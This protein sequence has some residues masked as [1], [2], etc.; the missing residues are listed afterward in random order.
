MTRGD[1]QL[2]YV[3]KPL[4]MTRTKLNVLTVEKYLQEGQIYVGI[5]ILFIEALKISS[6]LNVLQLIRKSPICEIIWK[7]V[8]KRRSMATRYPMK[9][10]M[11]NLTLLMDSMNN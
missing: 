6:A 3:P 2:N 7:S 4:E 1:D 8:I 10:L 5:T 11:I 9:S